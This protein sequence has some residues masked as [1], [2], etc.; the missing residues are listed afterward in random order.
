MSGCLPENNSQ[1]SWH[2]KAKRSV[3]TLLKGSTEQCLEKAI[4]RL[5]KADAILLPLKIKWELHQVN[6]EVLKKASLIIKTGGVYRD[7]DDCWFVLRHGADL[8]KKV[9]ASL[10]SKFRDMMDGD[11]PRGT[12]KEA[13]RKWDSLKKIACSLRIVRAGSDSTTIAC[14]KFNPMLL[15]CWCWDGRHNGICAHVVAVNAY[16]KKVD[17]GHWLTS[18]G[19]PRRKNRPTK[20]GHFLAH[21]RDETE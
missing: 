13:D 20:L 21:E 7:G 16:C 15:A 5:C 6:A 3:K 17:L 14:E 2:K 12:P 9:D 19:A 4:P 10:V 1:E 8:F 11:E 18:L